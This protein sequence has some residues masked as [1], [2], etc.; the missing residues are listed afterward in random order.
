MQAK[1]LD[2]KG[3]TETVDKLCF[4]EDNVKF[5]TDA[6]DKIVDFMVSL[7]KEQR[8]TF[9][10]ILE[11]AEGAKIFGEKGHE[12]DKETV[13]NPR[14]ALHIRANE[15]VKEKN[16]TYREAVSIAAQEHPEWAEFKDEATS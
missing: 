16:L 12:K 13:D 10:E 7:N 2:K 14:E 9:S 8:V 1:E 3:V 5:K 4:S 6:K 15:I 11:A